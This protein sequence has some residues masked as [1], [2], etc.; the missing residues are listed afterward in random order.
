MARSLHQSQKLLVGRLGREQGQLF[1]EGRP[2]GQDVVNLGLPGGKSDS[3]C[4]NNEKVE[5]LLR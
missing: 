1:L 5:F 4:A 3:P 2:S